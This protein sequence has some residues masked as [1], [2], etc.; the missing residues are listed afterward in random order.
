MNDR[1]LGTF[2]N[3]CLCSELFSLITL[4]PLSAKNA[5][6]LLVAEQQWPNIPDEWRATKT[7][8]K[9]TTWRPETAA[10]LTY[11]ST[12]NTPLGLRR[13]ARE[14]TLTPKHIVPQALTHVLPK[15]LESPPPGDINLQGAVSKPH[16][17][18]LTQ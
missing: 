14:H 11:S 17:V 15:H 6:L 1:P 13:E 8:A 3:S 16:R 2:E 7:G 18:Q 12:Q 10:P 5:Q 4:H 9:Q